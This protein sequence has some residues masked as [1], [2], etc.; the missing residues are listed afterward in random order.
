MNSCMF[1]SYTILNEACLLF[2][3]PVPLKKLHTVCTF[4]IQSIFE[5]VGYVI[6]NAK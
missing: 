1:I 4:T 3:G 5:I 6:C 2:S